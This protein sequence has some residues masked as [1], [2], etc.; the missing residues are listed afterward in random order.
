MEYRKKAGSGLRSSVES[1]LRAFV[2][3]LAVVC[4]CA[5]AAAQ[6]TE[7]MEL[8][9]VNPAGT[10]AGNRLSSNAQSS[11]D[12]R[13]VVFNSAATNLTPNDTSTTFDI[14]VR[15]LLL[16]TTTL[17]SVN[18]AG[19]G[20]GN[21]SSLSPSITPDGRFV[22]FV[23][24]ASDLVAGDSFNTSDIFVRDLQT[25][26]TKLVNINT[27]GTPSRNAVTSSALISDD[28][29]YVVFNSAASDLVAGDTNNK[30]D[31]FV[32]DLQLDTTTLVSVNSAGTGPGN[33]ASAASDITPDGRFVLFASD[34]S[35]LT[36]NDTSGAQTDTFRRD[37]QTNTTTLVSV[38]S[39]GTGSAGGSG[40]G[41]I[42]DDGRVVAFFSS[43]RDIVPP[44]CCGD[45]TSHTIY[46]RDLATNTSTI[47]S[48]RE[49]SQGTRTIPTPSTLS[50]SADGRYVFYLSR[51][52]NFGTLD[53]IAFR[54]RIFRR[55][56][57][58]NVLLELPFVPTGVCE[59]LTGFSCFSIVNDYVMSR[60]GRYVAYRQDERPS[61]NEIPASSAIIIRDMVGGGTE[62]IT[63][64]TTNSFD[65]SQRFII[66]GSVVAGG[67]VA[68]SSRF[69][70]SPT[71]T[72]ETT[73][74]YLFAP[75]A[76]PRVAFQH[77][78]YGFTENG[79]GPVP[80]PIR[81]RR[82]G[83]IID[84]T[85]TVK[86]STADGTATA[87]AD[88][89]PRSETLT[90]NPGESQKTI[91]LQLVNDEVAEPQETFTLNL[92]DPTGNVTIGSQGSATVTINDDEPPV[93]LMTGSTSI[94]ESP[95][96]FFLFTI[97]INGAPTG[98]ISVDYST[99]DGTASE[100]SDYITAAGRL[101]FAPGET[102]KS[103]R[104]FVVDD[105]F[106]E[107]DETL[108]FTLS[109]LQGANVTLGSPSTQQLTILSNDS[110]PPATNPIDN[111]QFFVRQHYL[112]FLNREP[113]A[114]GLAFWTNEIES[115]G[116]NAQCREVKRINVSA[117]FFLS[118]EFQETGFLAYLTNKAAFG[119]RP[120]FRQFERDVQN[121]QRGFVFGQS[122]PAVLEANK[123]AYFD[124]FVTRPEFT[125]KFSAMSNHQYVSTL[126][127]ENGMAPTVPNIFVARLEGQTPSP[128]N[129][130]PPGV[131]ILRRDPNAS[132]TTVRLSLQLNTLSSAPTA[133]HINGPT[134]GGGAT[135]L[136]TLPAREFADLPLTLTN[137]EINLLNAGQLSVDVHTQNNP[138]PE[139]GAQ[140]GPIR[141]RV[142]VLTEA[143]NN[144]T[145]T[146]AQVLRIIAES[147]ELRRAEL[148]AAFVQMEYFGYLRRD[149]DQAGFDFWLGKLNQFNGN[150]IEA[151]MVKAFI[152]SAEYRQRFGQ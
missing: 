75:P 20:G 81:V 43:S 69:R 67:K 30:T 17:V 51:E 22:L 39:D 37:L 60:D 52:V 36:A 96:S 68:F 87:G 120:L 143:L 8:V 112:D 101:T 113:D 42:S 54:D 9:S 31:V 84:S 91:T 139:L 76:T 71:D 19:T 10:E 40:G 6:T 64:T 1:L 137:E 88:Y 66:P 38:K 49:P 33:G 92:S 126:L 18:S 14:F 109:N 27:A 23:S 90:F 46:A 72:N 57:Q 34:A 107:P 85:A 146:R 11:A 47:V 78:A 2:L 129:T 15:D 93:V 77:A 110:P 26:T 62:V 124:E 141:F 82:N 45:F 44:E 41:A 147:E 149:P 35:D 79:T 119:A 102:V 100:R 32:R 145:L 118:I 74:V 7:F 117:A 94:T 133:V 140:L 98:T 122:S 114:D 13:F 136:H 24:Q 121:L 105:A 116:A 65:F 134:P 142:D 63:G 59:Q 61:N 48:Q 111:T 50:L 25:N 103:V 73:D 89:L 4:G 104:V 97:R 125:S 3:L 132:N 135:V 28:G 21:N 12:G 115:C 127:A 16:D 152:S 128:P 55:D 53:R 95:D 148:N 106:T 138:N 99:A 83:Y 108:S 80:G 144:V 5:P 56:L 130:T 29:R 86:F 131:F 123:R 70:H 150:Y 151:E 58:T